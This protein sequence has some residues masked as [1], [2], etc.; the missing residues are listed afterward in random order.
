MFD[1]MDKD[2]LISSLGDTV[3]KEYQNSGYEITTEIIKI[4]DEGIEA[5]GKYQL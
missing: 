4:S 5:I 1:E 2:D 3:L